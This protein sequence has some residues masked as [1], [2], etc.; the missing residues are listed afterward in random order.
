MAV[1]KQDLLRS[2]FQENQMTLL[3]SI[4]NKVEDL[5]NNSRIIKDYIS[6]DGIVADIDRSF[7]SLEDTIISVGTALK[8]SDLNISRDAERNEDRRTNESLSEMRRQ[9]RERNQNSDKNDRKQ[10]TRSISLGKILQVGFSTIYGFLDSLGLGVRSLVN[11]SQRVLNDTNSIIKNTGYSL[12][13]VQGFRGTLK[14]QV[15]SLNDYYMSVR[16]DSRAPFN[17]NDA[18]D[19]FTTIMNNSGITNMDFYEDYGKV[20]LKTATSMNINLSS[21]AT[22]SDQFYKRYSF[23]S[24]NMESL[25]TD[26]RKNS[27]GTS[28]TD[29]DLLQLV[30]ENELAVAA[31]ADRVATSQEEFT[32]L[33]EQGNKALESSAA[34]FNSL[35]ASNEQ[36][37]ELVNFMMRAAKDVTGPEAIA[38]NAITGRSSANI[39]QDL[40]TDWE[41]V[42][43]DLV[44]GLANLGDRELSN[45][46]L[47]TAISGIYNLS[48][49]M[50]DVSQIFSIAS[51]RSSTFMT[52]EEYVANRED[53]TSEDPI[54]DIYVG[55][56]QSLTNIE[57]VLTEDLAKF[58]EDTHT[59]LSFLEKIWNLLDRVFS[60]IAG[61][62]I[63]NFL[64]NLVLGRGAGNILGSG[65]NAAAGAGG[66]LS[67]AGGLL[68]GTATGI[69][70]GNLAGN[71]AG[72][73]A[74]DLGASRTEADAIDTS[75][76]LF[77]GGTSGVAVGVGT[78]AL[79]AGAGAKGALSAGAVAGLGAA[80]V[81]SPVALATYLML[82]DSTANDEL[83]Y[84]LYKG[85]NY[86]LG[87]SPYMGYRV[88][89]SDDIEYKKD[90]KGKIKTYDDGEGHVFNTYDVLGKQP[91]IPLPEEFVDTFISTKDGIIRYGNSYLEIENGS[92]DII[93]DSTR[94]EDLSSL[95]ESTPHKNYKTSDGTLSM[96]ILPSKSMDSVEDSLVEV[97][98]FNVGTSKLLQ[99]Q[100]AV[101]HEG[102]AII[103]SAYNPFDPE[104]YERLFRPTISL[105]SS[106]NY[107]TILKE[108]LASIKTI[109]NPRDIIPVQ[110]YGEE[111]D[112]V[113]IENVYTSR[114]T[115][116]PESSDDDSG[117]VYTKGVDTPDIIST[118]RDY[119]VEIPLDYQERQ[120]S[121]HTD[122][123]D[124]LSSTLK[125]LRDTYR[126]L[127]QWKKDNYIREDLKDTESNG[128]GGMSIGGSNDMSGFGVD[129][130]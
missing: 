1:L 114:D 78:K 61:I 65:A 76:T 87:Y 97:N 129:L 23:S 33:Q 41:S 19:L 64:T 67:T 9:T 66:I 14:D 99:D 127:E 106:I 75:T 84:E 68:A 81:L 95:F 50:K 83:M 15:K 21:L 126:F 8:G 45:Y 117:I 73:L 11:N 54:K 44:S 122:I 43:N 31:Y 55:V 22:F 89:F 82:K 53:K 128:G 105:G 63:G 69:T 85:D 79:L 32:A 26:I 3:I 123:S 102:E 119:K 4:E 124:T 130:G 101:V 94:I 51:R 96:D 58:Q 42:S 112:Q 49:T 74:E 116:I 107:S 103:P 48:D 46:G 52:S 10:E 93:D 108:I 16:E 17:Y 12:D 109:S 86:I 2:T 70:V 92:L 24:E 88:S 27:A 47:S 29:E 104:K 38:Y 56:E 62:G 59:D 118:I 120:S 34:Y 100:L 5:R 91:I 35:G 30:R 113:P 111:Y 20:F 13:T 60:S 37:I 110:S 6:R 98:S 71:A 57:S 125:V 7:E 121:E 115:D 39:L 72:N 40:F 28:L 36:S 77:T 25:L 90:R 80:K 18:L